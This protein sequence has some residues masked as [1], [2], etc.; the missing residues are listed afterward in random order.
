MDIIHERVAGLDVHKAM[1]VACVRVTADGKAGRTCRTFDTTTEGLKSLLDESGQPKGASNRSGIYSFLLLAWP[2]IKVMLEANPKRT[3][4][5]L[6]EWL[7]P[8]MRRDL[9]TYI[10]I[11]TLR[12]VCAP[13]PSGIGLSLRPL[14]KA[15]A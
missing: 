12:D 11:E 6:H 4:T 7:Q 10:E 15:S 1:I 5:D 2:E 8:Y 14:K 9:M 3:L 13:P